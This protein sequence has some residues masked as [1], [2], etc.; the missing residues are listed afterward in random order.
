MEIINIVAQIVGVLSSVVCV[1][2]L[3]YELVIFFTKKYPPTNPTAIQITR[4]ML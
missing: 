2:K 1:S 4:K 3:A